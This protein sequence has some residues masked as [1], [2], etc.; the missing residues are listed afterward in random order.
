MP[1]GKYS[2][3][4][5]KVNKIDGVYE[6]DKF[7]NIKVVTLMKKDLITMV[8]MTLSKRYIVCMTRRLGIIH[9]EVWNQSSEKTTNMELVTNQEKIKEIIKVFKKNN[10]NKILQFIKDE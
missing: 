5:K 6:M 9:T 2:R 4:T 10:Y 8:T 3:T 7:K 1:R